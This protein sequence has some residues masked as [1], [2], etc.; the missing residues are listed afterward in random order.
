MVRLACFGVGAE[1]GAGTKTALPFFAAHRAFCAAAIF[2]FVS[3]L[4]VRLPGV[5]VGAG[6][7]VGAGLP[8]QQ[9]LIQ[10]RKLGLRLP[11]WYIL[12]MA[13][14][15]CTTGKPRQRSKTKHYWHIW[16]QCFQAGNFRDYGCAVVAHQTQLHGL[17]ARLG[18]A[19]P[20]DIAYLPNITADVFAAHLGWGW[21]MGAFE[22]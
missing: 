15:L 14:N 8:G 6:A 18:R 4:K 12:E 2:A 9:A 22:E 20:L 19:I 10:G 3:A 1:T 16:G 21:K 17:L 5:V 13:G 11:T 7:G